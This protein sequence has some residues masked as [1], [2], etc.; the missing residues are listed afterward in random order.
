MTTSE[1]IERILREMDLKAVATKLGTELLEDETFYRQLVEKLLNEFVGGYGRG[2]SSLEREIVSRLA[3]K[4]LKENEAKL[5]ADLNMQAI[6]N[7][8]TLRIVSQAT[9]NIKR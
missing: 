1:L 4:F 5:M 8:M 9:D 6:V 7:G 3:D 2:T